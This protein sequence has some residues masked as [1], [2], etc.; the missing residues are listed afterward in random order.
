MRVNNFKSRLENVAWG[1]DCNTTT[2][3]CVCVW[4]GG[5]SK[6]SAPRV[7]QERGQEHGQAH[8]EATTYMVDTK[9]VTQKGKYPAKC[10]YFCSVYHYTS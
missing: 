4:G 9:K 1:K 8:D 2:S 3:V 10:N 7:A 5:V 6:K